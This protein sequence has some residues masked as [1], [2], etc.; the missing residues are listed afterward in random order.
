MSSEKKLL[1]S[2]TNKKLGQLSDVNILLCCA[3]VLC[4]NYYIK[5]NFR[6][7]S[8]HIHCLPWHSLHHEGNGRGGV[9]PRKNARKTNLKIL[10]FLHV[11]LAHVL[12]LNL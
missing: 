4:H 5:I 7:V 10:N 3:T 8:Q 6:G 12:H 2:N 9:E 1:K 11:F